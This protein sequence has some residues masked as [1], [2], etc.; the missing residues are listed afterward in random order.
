MNIPAK[1]YFDFYQLIK[2]LSNK[3]NY[4]NNLSF[5]MNGT[6][7]LGFALQRLNLK[8]NDKIILP[9]YICDSICKIINDKGYKII[10]LD[11]NEKL[12]LPIDKL[13][14]L[15]DLEKPKAVILVDYF[16]FLFQENLEIAKKIKPT[17]VRIILDQCHSA[18]FFQDF[19]ELKI[20]DAAIFSFR[21]TLAIN[22]GGAFWLKN[23]NIINKENL[24]LDYN[25][26]F[27]LIK[28]IIFFIIN[29]FSLF[30]IYSEKMNNLKYILPKKNREDY[31]FFNKPN[32]N[33][34]SRILYYQLT[35]KNYLISIINKRRKNIEHLN[36]QIENKNEFNQLDKKIIPQVF[37]YKSDKKGLLNY[38]NKKSI[39]AYKWPDRELPQEIR[40]CKD[41]YYYANKMN[42]E[43]IC[44]PIHQSIKKR[45]INYVA[46]IINKFSL[47][48]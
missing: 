34:I 18:N 38:L 31:R 47:G 16:G 8:K 42:D 4:I 14:F 28:S 20:F 21:K 43:I 39:G 48:Q 6:E 11:I 17:G 12:L 1:P 27:Y 7:A 46:K 29:F 5:T 25:F 30:N 10:Y 45:H 13:R 26:Y 32:I 9:A 36:T 2:P 40:R 3:N 23:S 41:L 35:E 15:I 44:L 37:V 19:S 22:Y 33:K 24:N